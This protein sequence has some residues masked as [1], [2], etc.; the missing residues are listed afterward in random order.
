MPPASAGGGDVTGALVDA[1]ASDPARIR[2]VARIRGSG[3]AREAGRLGWASRG[4]GEARDMQAW[5]GVKAIL[6]FFREQRHIP[7]GSF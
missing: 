7:T 2:G 1:R 3:G 6:S 4:S 5:G